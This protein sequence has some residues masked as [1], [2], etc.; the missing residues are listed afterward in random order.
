MGNVS[1]EEILRKNQKEMLEIKKHC[2]RNEEC[3]NGLSS[4]LDMIDKRIFELKDILIESSET[5]KKNRLK[6]KR[7]E[8]PRL[9]GH[10]KKM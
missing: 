1:R 6:R 9:M 4:K 8:Y 10:I 2:N 3:L 5:E 7:T